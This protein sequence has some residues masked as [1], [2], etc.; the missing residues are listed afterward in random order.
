MK[1]KNPIENYN[2]QSQ[3]TVDC[4][5]VEGQRFNEGQSDKAAGQV[6]TRRSCVW[7]IEPFGLGEAKESVAGHGLMQ[8]TSISRPC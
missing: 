3:L 5:G 2:I 1:T 4:L 8:A 6:D 7:T